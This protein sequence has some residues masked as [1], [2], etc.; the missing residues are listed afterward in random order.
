MTQHEEPIQK[1]PAS[2]DWGAGFAPLAT[3]IAAPQP[4]ANMQGLQP[5]SPS[6]AKPQQPQQA[7]LT[8][9]P[10]AS[11]ASSAAATAGTQ[12]QGNMLL[13]MFVCGGNG[14]GG[15]NSSSSEGGQLHAAVVPSAPPM[16]SAPPAAP[17]PAMQSNSSFGGSGVVQQRAALPAAA[18]PASNAGGASLGNAN[19]N[20]NSTSLERLEHSML[21]QADAESECVYNLMIG[22]L[23]GTWSFCVSTSLCVGLTVWY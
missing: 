20:A 8:N 12:A 10:A 17:A 11:D 2:L 21:A 5:R 4:Q 13:G 1:P 9:M 3:S 14:T 23:Y 7:P 19:A 6:N 18:V 22:T 15:R 16:P